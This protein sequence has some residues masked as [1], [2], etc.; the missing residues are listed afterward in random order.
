[1]GEADGKIEEMLLI[2]LDRIEIQEDQADQEAQGA[3]N[4]TG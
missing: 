3:I 2:V 4:R 1:M